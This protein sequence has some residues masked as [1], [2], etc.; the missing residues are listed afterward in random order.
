VEEP[1]RPANPP[2]PSPKSATRRH[3]ES[4]PDPA[5]K[6]LRWIRVQV[7]LMDA[8]LAVEVRRLL[9]LGSSCNYPK[10][11]DQPIREDSLLTGVLEPINFAYAVAKI[12]GITQ[13]QAVRQQYGLPWI[14][15]M[16][17]NLYGPGDNFSRVAYPSECRLAQGGL[18]VALHLEAWPSPGLKLLSPWQ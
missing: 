6:H 8:A 1:D 11:A 15:A 4:L 12:A 10:F 2:R 7:N 17:T 5:K 3:P 13:A 18:R 14:S 16:P 9:F